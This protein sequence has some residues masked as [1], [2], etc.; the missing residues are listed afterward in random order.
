MKE[1][2]NIHLE[3]FLIII[4]VLKFIYSCIYFYVLY[5]DTLEKSDV[6]KIQIYNRYESI[7]ELMVLFCFAILMMILF[8]PRK[9]EPILLDY[10]MKRNLFLLSIVLLFCVED[11][12]KKL[13]L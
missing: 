8:D 9:K 3:V 2:R 1:V 10:N 11:F 7:I 5:L 12:R 6:L 4:I 13:N